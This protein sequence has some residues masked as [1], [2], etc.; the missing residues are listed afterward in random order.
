MQDVHITIT[1]LKSVE[2]S[3]LDFELHGEFGYTL[4][5]SDEDFEFYII[6]KNPPKLLTDE[7]KIETLE[8]LIQDFK[9]LGA[10]H[11]RIVD[12]CNHH[13]YLFEA[14]KIELS[15]PEEAEKYQKDL[16][17]TEQYYKEKEQLKKKF[18]EEVSK[19]GEK[20]TIIY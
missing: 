16:E 12:H 3:E 2:E 6:P 10:T 1:S 19:L 15:T 8:N 7:L 4:K 14:L 18:T 11:I 9:G 5:H 17:S 20:Y 13:G